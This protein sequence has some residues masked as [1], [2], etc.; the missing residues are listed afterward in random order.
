MSIAMQ[1]RID[2]LCR[3]VSELTARV[4]ALEGVVKPPPPIPVTVPEGDNAAIEGD[5]APK[6]RPGRPRKAEAE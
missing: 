3:Q 4:R 5:D 6:R 1:A 2:D